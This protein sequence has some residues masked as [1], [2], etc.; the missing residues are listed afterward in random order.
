LQ[1]AKVIVGY[2]TYIALVPPHLLQDKEVVSTG[3]TREIERCRLALERALTGQRTAL[4]CSGD[5]GIYALA[6]LVYELV[7]V[8]DLAQ[9]VAIEVIPGVPALAAAAALLGAPLMHDFACISLS[10]LM[11]PWETIVQ[12]IKAVG[13]ADFVLVVY[14]P[15]SSKRRGQL[16]ETKKI[17][18]DF[19]SPTTPVGVV[20]QANRV[21]QTIHLTTLAAFD[22]QKVDMLSIV[23]IGNSQ[24]RFLG[25]KMVTPRGYLDKYRDKGH[26]CSENNGSF[27]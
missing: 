3:M 6:G 17:L 25:D 16:E 27:L 24:T 12:R 4:V 14:N 18:L 20:R 8:N 10:D 13:Q 19:R 15:R 21:G 5:P 2:K 22:T 9:S 1:E 7:A 26:F 11:T 23:I